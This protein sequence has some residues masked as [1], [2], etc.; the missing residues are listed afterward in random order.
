VAETYF[1][2]ESGE[3]GI[4]IRAMSKREAEK[5]IAERTSD[6][7]VEDAHPVFLQRL[8]DIVDGQFQ[9]VEEHAVVIVRGDVIVPQQRRV[10]TKWEL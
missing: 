3:D 4:D 2:I 5:E 7:Y 6:Q 1:W 9:D 10:V 8:P